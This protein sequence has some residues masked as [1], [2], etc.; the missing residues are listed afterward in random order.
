MFN[1]ITKTIDDNGR[2]GQAYEKAIAVADQAMI[3]DPDRAVGYRMLIVAAERFIDSTGRLPVTIVQTDASFAFFE[4]HANALR[5]AYAANDPTLVLEA[6][7]QVATATRAEFNPTVN[8][9]K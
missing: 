3:D 7:N 2:G 4:K 8:L 9:S 5:T 1:E 6:L